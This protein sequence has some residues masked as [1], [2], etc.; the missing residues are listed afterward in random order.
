MTSKIPALRLISPR[1]TRHAR[2]VG[3][4]EIPIPSDTA[5]DTIIEETEDRTC[6]LRLT[7]PDF[8]FDFAD[9]VA[10]FS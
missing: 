5:I 10:A 4:P 3:Q 1:V 6:I 9:P 8:V 2:W 7:N